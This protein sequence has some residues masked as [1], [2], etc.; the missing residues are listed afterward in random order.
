MNTNLKKFA[1]Q[2]NVSLLNKKQKAK[3]QGG[4][5]TSQAVNPAAKV[6]CF[7]TDNIAG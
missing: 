2:Q 5:S 3:V 7:I 6:A 4:D 1:S